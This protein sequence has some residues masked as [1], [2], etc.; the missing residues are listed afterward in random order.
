MISTNATYASSGTCS[1]NI[2]NCFLKLSDTSAQGS[3][4]LIYIPNNTASVTEKITISNSTLLNS[5]LYKSDAAI[6]VLETQSEISITNS[7]IANANVTPIG[8]NQPNLF[9]ISNVI[10]FDTNTVGTGF[11]FSDSGTGGT[12]KIYIGARCVS[13][14]KLPTSSNDAFLNMTGGILDCQLDLGTVLPSI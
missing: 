12:T 3:S 1:Y 9:Y 14:F 5:G 7:V 4:T 13:N 8:I 11:T 6:S 10:F 2:S